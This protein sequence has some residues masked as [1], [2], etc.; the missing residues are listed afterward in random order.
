MKT[1]LWRCSITAIL[2]L[3]WVGPARAI[4]LD[5]RGE[6][7]MSMRTYTDVRIGTEA[8]GSKENPQNFPHSAFG[9]VRQHRYFLDLKFNH[10]LKRLAHAGW[11][12]ARSFEWMNPDQ[13]SYTLHYRGE[14]EGLYDYGPNEYHHI[15]DK[16]RA[17]RLD[18]PKFGTVTSPKVP[19]QYLQDKIRRLRRIARMRNRFFLGYLD[20]ENGRFFMRVGRQILAW[21]ETDVFRLLDNINPL[22]DSFGGFFI[23][24]DERRL[25][26]DM[27]RSSYQIGSIGPLHDMFIEA[28]GALGNKDAQQPGTPDGSPWRPGGLGYPR[29]Q[30]RYGNNVPGTFDLRGGARLVFTTADTTVTL[31]HYHTYFDIPGVRFIVPKPKGGIPAASYA[32]Q[33]IAVQTFPRVP[34]TGLAFTT[35]LPSL[36]SILRGEAAYFQ[37]EPTN[38]Q[39]IGQ[40]IDSQALPGTPGY[41]RL[42]NA[43]NTEGGLDP[44]VY[45][46]FFDG[47]RKGPITAKLLQLDSFNTSVGWDLNIFF[48]PLNP[49]QSFFITTQF[50]FKHMF[51][52]PGDL[53]LPVGYRNIAVD[54]GLLLVGTPGCLRPS[55]NRTP[56]RARPRLY[57]LAD[58]RLLHTLLITTSYFSGK[59]TPSVGMFYD[60]QGGIVVQ[61]GVALTQDPFR[62]IVD[63]TRVAGPPTGQ[64]GTVRDRDNVRV[65]IEYV[66]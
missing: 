48:R 56:C 32:N 17:I 12:L 28:F 5:D 57:H 66:F 24:L 55:G 34:V 1:A 22:D 36:Y 18:L 41:N 50:F 49:A 52:S 27:V 11:G 4:V 43:H 14:G 54:K 35:A 33:I 47:T 39:G 31:A 42:V 61:P 21:G 15:E 26:L 9:H 40:S 46:R 6:M 59:V 13:L 63:Y 19:E 37:G 45:P 51:D 65:Q 10:D 25:P 62:F 53:I 8:I 58:D 44:F 2:A 7:K 29:P 60:W 16:Y 3:A 30:L 64:F 20:Y 38:R 23:A